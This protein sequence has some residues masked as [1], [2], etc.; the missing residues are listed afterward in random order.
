MILQNFTWLLLFV[1]LAS[2]AQ[3]KSNEQYKQITTDAEPVETPVSKEGLKTAYFAS[4]CFW[5]S[6][7][8]YESVIGVIDV[9]SGYSGGEGKNPT[10]NNYEKKGH[11]EVVEVTYDPHVID[12]KSLLT[13]YFGSQ[14]A[15]QQ[16]GQGPDQGRGYRSIVFYQNEK[17]KNQIIKKIEEVQKNY[18][19]PIAAQVVP[20]RKFYRAEEFHQD[21]EEQ[22]PNNPYIRS[23]SLPRLNN[24]QLEHPELLK[25]N[26]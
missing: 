17:Q 12:F 11:A 22:N 13:V 16:N 19:K 25:E 8:I 23:V 5:C 20:F 24:F 1:T 15:T 4:G 10:Y 26:Q 3:K 18:R 9:V 14:N 6:E 21:F 2:C 7:S